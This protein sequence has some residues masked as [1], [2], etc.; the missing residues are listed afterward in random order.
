MFNLLCLLTYVLAEPIFIRYYTG[1]Y[2]LLQ[3]LR[4]TYF[5][6]I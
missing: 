1:I 4:L 5:Y 3:D 6:I 2:S